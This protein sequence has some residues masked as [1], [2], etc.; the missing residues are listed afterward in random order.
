MA[1][2]TNYRGNSGPPSGNCS[3][4]RFHFAVFAIAT[5]PLGNQPTFHQIFNFDLEMAIAKKSCLPESL[6]SFL[7]CIS[8]LEKSN[9]TSLVSK[10]AA[11]LP[12]TILGDMCEFGPMLANKRLVPNWGFFSLIS[13]IRHSLGT[14]THKEAF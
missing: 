9:T 1:F 6:A 12:L 2:F 8:L 5:L 14:H 11:K 7:K 3:W 10:R 13:E 4:K